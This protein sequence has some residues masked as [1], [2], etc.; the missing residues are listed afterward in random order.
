MQMQSRQRLSRLLREMKMLEQDAPPGI[1][2]WPLHE[3]DL[4]VIRAQ[5][6]GPPGS[7]YEEGSFAC[8]LIIPSNY[9]FE[10]PKVST[11]RL[12]LCFFSCFH[13]LVLSLLVAS[14]PLSLFRC[15]SLV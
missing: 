7:P 14:A 15:F 9:P 8:E 6:D 13:R 11:Q 1:S 10:P 2:A 4:S 3:D 5:I 12:L